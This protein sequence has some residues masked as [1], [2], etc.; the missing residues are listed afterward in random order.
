MVISILSKKIAMDEVW[1]HTYRKRDG[2]I[3]LGHYRKSIFLDPFISNIVTIPIYAE[4][5][6]CIAN[7]SSK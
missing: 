4:P 7:R 5:V 3:V 1:V 2:T 6:Y